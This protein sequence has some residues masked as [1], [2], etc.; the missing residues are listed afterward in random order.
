VLRTLL[1]IILVYLV[2]RTLLKVFSPAARNE[3][4]KGP[5]RQTRPRVDDARIQDA[6]FKDLPDK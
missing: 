6:T 3:R 1:I 4:V 2:V 5:K